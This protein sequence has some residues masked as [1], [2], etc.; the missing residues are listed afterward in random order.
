[1]TLVYEEIGIRIWTRAEEEENERG[2]EI[3]ASLSLGERY[4]G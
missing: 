4:E 3:L 1:M 2:K